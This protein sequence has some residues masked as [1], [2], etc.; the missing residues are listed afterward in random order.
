MKVFALA[1]LLSLATET[2][3]VNLSGQ[4][5]PPTHKKL[6]YHPF[7]TGDNER[8]EYPEE[9]TAESIAESEKELHKKMGVPNTKEI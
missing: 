1:L 6:N 3:A 2:E 4:Y 5:R 7:P 8:D 9:F